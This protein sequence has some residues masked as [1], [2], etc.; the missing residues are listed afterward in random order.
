LCR[1]DPDG[2]GL[3]T[4]FRSGACFAYPTSTL[5]ALA[6]GPD[7]RVAA[8]GQDSGNGYFIAVELTRD[9]ERQ[10]NFG[11]MF[12]IVA[13]SPGFRPLAT[14]ISVPTLYLAGTTD[15]TDVLARSIGP[16]LDVSFGD[17]EVKGSIPAPGGTSQLAAVAVQG[18]G[19]VV[20]A[21]SSQTTST[22]SWIMRFTGTGTLDTTFGPTGSIGHPTV[23]V[24]LVALA[25][26]P[27]GRIVVAG[28]RQ[29]NGVTAA[30]LWP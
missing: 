20:A 4:T 14:A 28:T 18:D 10:P 26:Q 13:S 1:L 30:R 19:K 25:I 3:D 5:Y 6:V 15:T 7:D 27:D 29:G 22:R 8:V 2:R 17:G 23:G 11:N 16:G 12:G 9:G 21:G 24:R